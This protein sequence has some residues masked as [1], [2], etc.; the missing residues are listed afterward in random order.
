M[1]QSIWERRQAVASRLGEPRPAR[2]GRARRAGTTTSSPRRCASRTSTP[3][4][5]LQAALA[6]VVH[7]ASGR[8]GFDLVL[9]GV[10]H[11]VRVRADADGEVHLV[12]DGGPGRARPA[13]AGTRPPR[14]RQRARLAA[15]AALDPLRDRVAVPHSGPRTTRVGPSRVPHRPTTPLARPDTFRPHVLPD[16]SC[17]RPAGCARRKRR[18]HDLPA[19]SRPGGRTL[20]HR[21]R[22]DARP[23]PGPGVHRLHRV[24]GAVQ[25]P[26]AGPGH[27]RARPVRRDPEATTTPTSAPGSPPTPGTPTASASTPPWPT[28]SPTAPTTSPTATTLDQRRSRPPRRG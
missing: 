1:N 27:R 22:G 26:A 24:Q 23:D 4:G 21:L 6:A 12:R 3:R 17:R 7:V 8:P 15:L 16:C 5:C 28:T 14:R 20:R 25:D 9:A 11:G 10:G 18:S 13:G 2:P 19:A